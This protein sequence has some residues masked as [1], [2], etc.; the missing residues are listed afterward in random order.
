MSEH[1]VL[2]KAIDVLV[3]ELNPKKILLFGS[4]AKETNSKN[5]DFDLALDMKR[6]DITKEREVEEKID[7]IAGLYSVDVVYL[8]SVEDDFRKIIMKTGKVIYERGN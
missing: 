6:P 3:G 4:R 7:E 1:Q 2:N 8:G 5:A